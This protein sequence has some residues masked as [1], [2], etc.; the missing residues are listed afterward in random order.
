MKKNDI[1]SISKQREALSLVE[2]GRHDR[3]RP[4]LVELVR[5]NPDNVK[6]RYLL[7]VCETLAGDLDLAEATFRDVISRMPQHHQALYGLGRVLESKG[8]VPDAIEVWRMALEI[9]PNFDYAAR[10][11]AQYRVSVDQA[12]RKTPISK[13]VGPDLETKKRQWLE[14]VLPGIEIPTGLKYSDQHVWIRIDDEVGTVGITDFFRFTQN[15]GY[16][17]VDELPKVG[18]MV[19]FG[20]IISKITGLV[21]PE[22]RK[23]LYP[24]SESLK[25][26]LE[27]RKPF[28]NGYGR[29]RDPRKRIWISVPSPVSGRIA[30]VN[31]P[32]IRKGREYSIVRPRQELN[33]IFP[34]AEYSWLFRIQ[35][36][37]KGWEDLEQL[38]D[39]TAYRQF[40]GSIL[41]SG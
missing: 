19:E 26:F 23:R 9:K 25:S 14:K 16:V 39:D 31:K 33:L 27:E 1:S 30:N 4:I 21:N 38:M 34:Y 37:N 7:G 6:A 36:N 35:L 24:K 13:H 28:K 10:K 41:I 22:V 5:S 29:F 18:S 20:Q 3:A 12:G 11:L 40:V 32:L 15:P 17:W 8:N 2:S